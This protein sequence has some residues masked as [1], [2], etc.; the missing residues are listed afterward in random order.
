[1]SKLLIKFAGLLLMFVL[2]ACDS[3]LQDE[4]PAV[5]SVNNNKL[6]LNELRA[7]IPQNAGLEISQIQVQHYI[8][9]WMENELLYQKAL[10]EGL[11][12]DPLIQ[13]RLQKLEKDYLASAYLDKVFE[14]DVVVTDQQIKDFYKK[15]SASFIRPETLYDVDM[16][17]VEDLTT[18][19]NLRRDIQGGNTFADV[20]KENSI[21]VSKND[22]GKLGWIT[23]EDLP[24]ELS[25]SVSRARENTISAPV[26]SGLGYH[27]FRV[28]EVREKGEVQTL[29]E[30]K[31][32]IIARLK[33]G[34]REEKY[35][36]LV[37]D[38]H[39]E[40]EVRINWSMMDSIE[41][42]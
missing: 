18:A 28:N 16:I 22:G 2:V 27:V 38:L 33:A 42:K 13:K 26:R 7:T 11:K 19:R 12:N 25:R 30:V 34:T 32:Q 20:A 14:R 5:A 36:Q 3:S 6:T 21:D 29:E 31:D 4:S 1:L 41:V 37:K 39:E 8:Q 17:L 40:A 10:E 24:V 23:L 15:E 9:T 35:R